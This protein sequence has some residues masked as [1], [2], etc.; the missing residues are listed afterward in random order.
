YNASQG[1]FATTTASSTLSDTTPPAVTLTAPA[2]NSTVSGAAVT[3]SADASDAS[4]V[5]GVQFKLDGSNL[6]S[7]VTAAPYSTTWNS[8]LANSGSHALTAVGRD[9]AGNQAVSAALT[10]T[11][12]NSAPA[13]NSTTTNSVVW[14]D[15]S[16]PTGAAPGADGGDSWNWI[17]SNPSPFAGSVA[18]QSTVGT[19]LHQHFFA[20]A[21]Q[22]L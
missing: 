15:D 16:L 6:G 18:N 2:A 1:A 7:E 21:T 14:L 3:V 11:V 17:S 10:V 20:W 22:T 4:G 9:T 12:A 19:G 5:A 13:T 8:T